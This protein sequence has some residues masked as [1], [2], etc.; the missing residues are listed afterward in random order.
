MCCNFI[1]LGEKL[2]LRTAGDPAGVVMLLFVLATECL[3]ITYLPTYLPGGSTERGFSS[4]TLPF[5]AVPPLLLPAS[6]SPL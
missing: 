6:F 2:F 3:L 5:P 1:F 4:S